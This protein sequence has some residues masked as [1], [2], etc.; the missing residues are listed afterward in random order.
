MDLNT[1]ETYSASIENDIASTF[2]IPLEG[3]EN[4]FVIS[5]ERTVSIIEW[6]GVDTTARVIQELFSVETGEMYAN[7]N[8]NIAKASPITCQFY[9]GIFR[10]N[11]CSNESGAIASLY[12]YSN[13]RGVER[14]VSDL[15]ISG[16]LDWNVDKSLFYHIDSCNL[17]IREYYWD[18][19]SGNICA[20]IMDYH[21]YKL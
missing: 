18:P 4:Q 20:F 19:I 12:T 3:R 17:T 2:I 7:N 1:N 16:G 11:L 14:L 8:W 15:K 9:G 10:G 13:V 21:S 6:D 5:N